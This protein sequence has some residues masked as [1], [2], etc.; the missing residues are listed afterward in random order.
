MTDNNPDAENGGESPST[1]DR[2]DESG[3]AS[4]VEAAEDVG[5][6][7]D[8]IE[9]LLGHAENLL[10]VFDDESSGE[11]SKDFVEEF[12]EV[13]DEASELLE[14]VDIESLP[15][16]IDLSELP[17]VIEAENLPEAIENRDP[18]ALLAYRNLADLVELGELW[19]SVDVREFWRNHRELSEEFDDVTDYFPDD[20]PDESA[21]DA[22]GGSSSSASADPS[23]S[24]DSDS[25]LLESDAKQTAIQKGVNDAVVEFREGILEARTE[26][27]RVVE[28]NRQRTGTV[29]QPNSRN[30]TAVSTMA[31]QRGYLSGGLGRYSTVPSETKY[32]TAPNHR[33]IYGDRFEDAGGEGDE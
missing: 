33:R 22:T 20:E 23:A 25:D 14:T 4:T 8:Q 29:G 5:I 32:S 24:T 13:L 15:D 16:A 19:D 6:P 31:R 10:A 7:T 17:E 18:K 12:S 30:P 11:P 1:N 26:L 9:E 2:G 21:D 3:D 28:E 27:K